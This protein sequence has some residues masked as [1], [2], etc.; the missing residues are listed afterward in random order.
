MDLSIREAKASDMKR[1]L[2][3][4]QELATF[5]KEPDAV[6][7]TEKD[8]IDGLTAKQPLFTCFVA[9]VDGVVQGM[10]LCYP[11]YSTW[12]GL[13]VHLEDLIVT[14]SLRGKGVGK[15]LYSAVMKHAFNKK[16]R[17]VEWVVL[18]W[19]KNAIDFYESTGAAVDAQWNIA[20]MNEVAL[21]NY[22]AQL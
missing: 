13:T 22:V 8:L 12:K 19:N 10:A 6:E 15:A 18:D 4:I 9:E 20:Q 2:E 17:R 21:K 11:R 3:L 16:V 7:V 14:Q 5:E 1:V